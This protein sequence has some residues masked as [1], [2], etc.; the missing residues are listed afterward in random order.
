MTSSSNNLGKEGNFCKTHR[1]GGITSSTVSRK[2][3]NVC[4]ATPSKS[5]TQRGETLE[6]K[7]DFKKMEREA[8]ECREQDEYLEEQRKNRESYH[9]DHRICCSDCPHSPHP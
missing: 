4:G 6:R 1:G 3:C 7:I 2:P 9:G 5:G 8:K